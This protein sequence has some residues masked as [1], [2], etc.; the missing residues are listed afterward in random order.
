MTA[1]ETAEPGAATQEAV[2]KKYANSK[3]G[4]VSRTPLCF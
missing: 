4:S 1:A 3:F 2:Q